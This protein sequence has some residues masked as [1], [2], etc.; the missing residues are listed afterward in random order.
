MLLPAGYETTGKISRR[1]IQAFESNLTMIA[2]HLFM[3][4]AKTCSKQL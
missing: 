2:P 1:F 4:F 3:D